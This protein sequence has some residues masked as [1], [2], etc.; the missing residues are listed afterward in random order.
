MCPICVL[1]LT[2]I[3]RWE[4]FLNGFFFSFSEFSSTLKARLRRDRTE[5][6]SRQVD[7]MGALV[8]ELEVKRSL[9]PPQSLLMQ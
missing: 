9:C 3:F 4:T 5:Q 6:L 8:S 7:V 2:L 1:L